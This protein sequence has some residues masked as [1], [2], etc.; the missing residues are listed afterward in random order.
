MRKYLH[1]LY[2]VRHLFFYVVYSFL[3]TGTE[4]DGRGGVPLA[5]RMSNHQF[6]ALL[7]EVDQPLLHLLLKPGL[8]S[9]FDATAVF[10]MTG[11][12]SFDDWVVGIQVN[13]GLGGTPDAGRGCSDSFCDNA[14]LDVALR[15]EGVVETIPVGP[16]DVNRG[17]LCYFPEKG[18]DVHN[19]N[20]LRQ[21]PTDW[22]LVVG[23][24]RSHLVN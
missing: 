20:T 10:L 24:C 15:R 4:V 5:S 1:I 8:L 17:D 23:C 19:K 11:Q 18:L 9:L 7:H 12:P 21:I 3:L 6:L 2:V 16:A 22:L 14:R 13:Q